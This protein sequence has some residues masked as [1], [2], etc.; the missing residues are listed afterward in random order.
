MSY[1]DHHT[2]STDST[3]PP[4]A[5]ATSNEPIMKLLFDYPGADIIL[6]SQDS[7]HLRV[8]KALIINYS[9]VL[10]EL[11][12]KTFDSLGNANAEA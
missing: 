11:K 12:R 8:P 1:K 5:A 6:R 10:G 3:A 9:P 2:M 7:H 4:E